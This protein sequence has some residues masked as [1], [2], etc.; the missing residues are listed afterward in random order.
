MRNG[1]AI[2]G[3]T[4]TGRTVQDNC[5]L[6]S[7]LPE[8]YSWATID[9]T[10]ALRGDSNAGLTSPYCSITTPFQTSF[11]GLLTYVVPKLD[12]QLAATWRSDPGP[13]LAA[14]YV[15]TNAIA[16]SGPQPLGRN[17]SA[18]NITVNLVAPGTLYGDRLNNLDFR[19]AKILHYRRMR[20]QLGLDVYNVMNTD[21]VT[22]YNPTFV[23]GGSWLIPA[24]VN[25]AR[26]AK[27]N[28]Q[29]DF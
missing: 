23:P 10:Q 1:L 11:R 17:L 21:V 5:A 7:A 16:Q 4:S 12:L 15:V 29:I 13:A 2:Q 28:V 27:V 9:I 6:R 19:V 22:T 26:Y 14:N 25:P 18:G 24:T 3:G 8:T 20:M